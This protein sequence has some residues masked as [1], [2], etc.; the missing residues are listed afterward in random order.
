MTLNNHT[1]QSYDAFQNIIQ[2]LLQMDDI[3]FIRYKAIQNTTTE[4]KRTNYLLRTYIGKSFEKNI[5]GIYLDNSLVSNVSVTYVE[6][7]RN[8][9]DAI[10]DYEALFAG[11]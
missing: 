2:D 5:G 10:K 8:L 3:R 4:T 11:N 1:S 7:K 6:G 9:D